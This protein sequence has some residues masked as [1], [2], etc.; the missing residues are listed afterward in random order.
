MLALSMYTSLALSSLCGSGV[1]QESSQF[2][3]GF[4]RAIDHVGGV[5]PLARCVVDVQPELQIVEQA[6]VLRLEDGQ[7]GPGRAEGAVA[8][9]LEELALG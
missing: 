7:Y 4:R 9:A 5:V 1:I 8:L 6:E 2:G 3:Q